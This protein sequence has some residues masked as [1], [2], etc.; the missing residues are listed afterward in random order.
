MFPTRAM[1]IAAFGAVLLGAATPALA[2]DP[3]TNLGPVGPREPI[4]AKV[5]DKRVIAYYEPSGDNCYVSAVMF[6]DSPSGGGHASTR[7]RVALHPGEL[8]DVDGTGDKRVVLLCGFK[9]DQLTVLNRHQ[10]ED[11]TSAIQ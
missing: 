6:D 10:L 8:F 11:T 5:G 7:V 4:L 1:T 3:T 9:G 2:Q